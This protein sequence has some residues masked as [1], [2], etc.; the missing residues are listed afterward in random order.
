[1]G[2]AG[3][4]PVLDVFS[5]EDVAFSSMIAASQS[6]S[7]AR[8]R[9]LLV[10]LATWFSANALT[11]IAVAIATGG[12][13]YRLPLLGL[14]GAEA[15]I[16]FLNF[17]LPILAVRYILREPVSFAESFGW[18][19]TGWKVPALAGGGF[20]VFLARDPAGRAASSRWRRIPASVKYSI[21]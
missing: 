5:S 1:M 18:R 21:E 14:L 9:I 19:W 20:I 12:I 7:Q 8:G 13:Y 3:F 2:D 6:K 4:D 15:S 16:G 10:L 17:F 11:H